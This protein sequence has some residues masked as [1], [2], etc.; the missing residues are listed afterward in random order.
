[1]P[2][3]QISWTVDVECEGDH[4]AAA[5]LIAERYFAANIAAGEHDSACVFTVTD[6]AD[7]VGVEIDLADSLS[8]LEGD[9]TL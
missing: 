6:E 1:M 7:Q 9:D 4:K 2:R 3:Y 5:Q 8:D